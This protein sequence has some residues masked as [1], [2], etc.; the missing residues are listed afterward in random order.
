MGRLHFMTY[1]IKTVAKSHFSGIAPSLANRKWINTRL[2]LE[3]F[4]KNAIR[5]LALILILAMFA[6]MASG[7]EAPASAD[8]IKEPASVSGGNI[9]TEPMQP[10]DT[11]SLDV[12]IVPETTAPAAQVTSVDEMIIVDDND[13]KV[14][15]K[16]LDETNSAFS[17]L[18]VLIENNTEKS[19]T[20]R[21]D[22]CSINDCMID[23]TLY[24][25]VAPGKKANTEIFFERHSLK[26][27]GIAD[28]GEIEFKVVAFD[29]ETWEDYFTST[30][31]VIKTSS[32]G[33]APYE[34]DNSGHPV[35]NADGIEIVVQ[36]IVT[37]GS[38]Q[39]GVRLFIHNTS[40]RNINLNTFETSVN[41]FMIDSYFGAEI[42]SGKYCISD[43]IFDS[44]ELKLNG[45]ETIQNAELRLEAFDLA[46]WDDVLKTDAIFIDFVE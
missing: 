23:G 46:T 18:R 8:G 42:A 7:C 1:Y 27:A 41:G 33:T 22:D 11:P 20:F 30:P 4:M 45:I 5:T 32:A 44:D 26:A 24:E 28:I 2:I 6:A 38:S 9:V 10:T 21:V 25:I 29:S 35:Y 12:S 39:T 14:T 43:I 40:S 16:S 3:E 31:I 37:D 15:V 13:V 19:L 36:G 17:S 34:Y